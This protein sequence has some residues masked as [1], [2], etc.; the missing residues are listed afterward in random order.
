MDHRSLISTVGDEP[1]HRIS[2][3]HHNI[4]RAGRHCVTGREADLHH[5]VVGGGAEQIVIALPV[6]VEAR[7][8][9][10][11]VVRITTADAHLCVE[12]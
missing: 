3:L 12:C 6:E 5:Q 1:Q 8:I 10:G 9:E 2:V 7:A 4:T 11:G